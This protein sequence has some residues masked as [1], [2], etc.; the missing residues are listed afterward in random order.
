MMTVAGHTDGR[1]MQRD[2]GKR[3]HLK[4]PEIVLFL[5][6]FTSDRLGRLQQSVLCVGVASRYTWK[7]GEEGVVGAGRR[8]GRV[9][10]RSPLPPHNLLVDGEE[11]EVRRVPLVR[12]SVHGLETS[13]SCD[14]LHPLGLESVNVNL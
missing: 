11:V 7:A 6:G 1:E 10:R 5:C 3:G 8:R 12:A 13:L 9:V 2:G 14:V 4:C